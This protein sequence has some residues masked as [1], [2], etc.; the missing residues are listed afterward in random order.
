M[1]GTAF[2][3]GVEAASPAVSPASNWIVCPSGLTKRAVAR[4]KSY[5]SV[6]T[7]AP[8]EPGA[9]NAGSNRGL[10]SAACRRE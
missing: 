2:S 5:V 6:G 9:G 3:A 10:P 4:Y 1:P 8:G 7:F